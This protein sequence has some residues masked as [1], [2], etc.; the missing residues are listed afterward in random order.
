MNTPSISFREHNVMGPIRLG[1]LQWKKDRV[2]ILW[3]IC[4][5]QEGPRTLAL[6]RDLSS[7]H[8]IE[9]LRLGEEKERN[10]DSLQSKS[11][12]VSSQ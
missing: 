3:Q 12:L 10:V 4:A 11:N 5:I 7:N 9:M 6:Q 2:A 1:T 8:Q